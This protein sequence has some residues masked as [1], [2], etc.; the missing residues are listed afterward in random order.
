MD[1]E[2]LMGPR[3]GWAKLQQLNRNNSRRGKNVKKQTGRT[4]ELT[5]VSQTVSANSQLRT[6]RMDNDGTGHN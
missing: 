4:E 2:S 5:A 3:E 1:M 6:Q